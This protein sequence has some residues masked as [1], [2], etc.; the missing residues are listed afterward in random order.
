MELKDI[1][2]QL[3]LSSYEASVY[4]ASLE[5]GSGT[6]IQ[7]AKKAHIKR[8]TCYDVLID[9]K[10]KGLIFESTKE[11]RRFFI[12]EDPEKLKKDLERK[13]A[14]FLEALPQFRSLYNISGVKPKIRFYEGVE[15]IKEVYMDTLKYSGGFYAFGSEDIVKIVGQDWMNAFIKKRTK[16]GVS[17]RAILP[18][19]IYTQGMLS[20]KDQ[21]ELRS[22]KLIEKNKYPFSIEI[23]IYGHSK[24]SLISAKETLA[25][26]I[27]SSEIYNTMKL[28]FEA[29]WDHLPEIEKR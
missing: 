26:I 27:E 23:D 19:T 29:L 5:L 13:E 16:K 7:I 4:L 2:E 21:K 25:V 3:G 12:A 8:T 9:L 11:K 22:T 1:L 18:K 28:I 24:I 14:V 10:N 15:G 20:E 6:T 17:V